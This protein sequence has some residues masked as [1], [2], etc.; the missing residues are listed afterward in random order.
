LSTI[1]SDGRQIALLGSGDPD[2]ESRY[3]A[4]AASNPDQ[5]SVS[6]GYDEKLAHQIQAGVDA[7]VVPSRFEPCG[8]TQL[9]ALRYGAVAIVSRV[10]GLADTEL[11][12][13]TKRLLPAAKQPESNLRRLRSKISLA[14]SGERVPCST[15]SRFGEAFRKKA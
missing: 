12:T 7:L 3:G 9:C 4:V 10:G 6:I 2:L 11:L 8:L 14:Q 15:T 13:P 5:I 1:V